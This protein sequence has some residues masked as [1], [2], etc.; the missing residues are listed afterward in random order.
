[1]AMPFGLAVHDASGTIQFV[2]GLDGVLHL[3]RLGAA[4]LAVTATGVSTLDQDLLPGPPS[5][6]PGRA[7]WWTARRDGGAHLWVDGASPALHTL[8]RRGSIVGRASTP[9]AIESVTVDDTGALLLVN[10][11]NGRGHLVALDPDGR[12]R[13]TIDLPHRIVPEVTLG[14]H[15]EAWVTSH[16][17]GVSL[18]EPPRFG[19]RSTAC[20]PM[21]SA[22]ISRPS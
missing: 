21:T 12:Q 13:W 8:D 6:L 9:P 22:S 20:A 4:T 17:G 16:D 7:R 11:L 1:V 19:A 3:M 18:V 15:G 5:P 14:S 2:P 10:N